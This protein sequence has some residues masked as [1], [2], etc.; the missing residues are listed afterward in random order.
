FSTGGASSAAGGNGG[1]SEAAGSANGPCTITCNASRTCVDNVCSGG[2]VPM[3][4]PPPQIAARS[5]AAVVA[6]GRSVFIWGGLNVDNMALNNGA[7]YDPATDVWTPLPPDPGS[8]SARMLATAV[9]TGAASNK[10]IVFGGS[11]AGGGMIYK[12]GAIY[13]PVGN[14]WSALPA[15]PSVSKRSSPYGYWDG[16]RAVFYGGLIN[17]N[18]NPQAVPGADRYDLNKW[19]T[20]PTSGDPGLLGFSATAFDGSVMYLQGGVI[21]GV[22]QDKV[23]A[24]T[25]STNT[26]ASLPKGPSPRTGGFGVWDGT[27]FVVWGG[28]DD[29]G[30]LADGKILSGMA[31]SDMASSDVL[32]PRRIGSGRAGWAFQVNPG[33]VAMLGGQT[34]MSGSSETLVTDGATYVVD[35]GKWAAI[36]SWPSGEKHEYGM[37][38]WTGEEFVIWG[39][40][41]QNVSSLTGER[42]AP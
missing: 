32:S 21:E 3:A 18:T 23:F 19:S 8:P 6:V 33:V 2:W 26:W 41:T 13:D 11:D 37:G 40:R 38:V 16:T 29:A 28:Q 25:S 9:W 1:E 31:W 10:V 4:T 12:D 35:S 22:R 27:H 39:G 5:K 14:S 24:Y 15:A 17:L 30:M 42:W 36:P 20:S 7:I 34:S